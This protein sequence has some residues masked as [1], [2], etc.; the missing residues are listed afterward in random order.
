MSLNMA[1]G[2]VDSPLLTRWCHLIWL[3]VTLTPLY[4]PGDVTKYGYGW[5]WLPFIDQVMSLNMALGDI[6]PPLLTRWCHLIWL[7]VTLTPLYWPGDVTYSIM[8]L[9]KFSYLSQSDCSNW[10]MWQVGDAYPRPGWDG[11]LTWEKMAFIKS[12]KTWIILLY[13]WLHI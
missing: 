4:W 11:C 3:W 12:V 6:D 8:M 7:W 1:M 13:I 5:R 2:D 9:M 10:V